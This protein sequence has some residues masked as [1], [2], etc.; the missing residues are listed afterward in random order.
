MKLR[1]F[2]GCLVGAART[3]DPISRVPRSFDGVVG[4]VGHHTITI[5]PPS[6]SRLSFSSVIKGHQ[7]IGHEQ[8]EDLVAGG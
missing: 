4:L 3:R 7:I 5:E 8:S 2:A 6:H 1:T